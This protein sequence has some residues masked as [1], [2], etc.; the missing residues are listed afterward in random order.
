LDG[1][2]LT[3]TGPEDI[4]D[5]NLKLILGMVRIA[6][7]WSAGQA[8]TSTDLDAHSALSNLWHHVSAPWKAALTNSEEG[9]SARDG[10]L[11]WCQRKTTPYDE[12]KVQNFKQS[13]SDG[14]A[15]C[16]LIHRHRPELIDWEKLDKNDRRG[17]TA[18]AFKVAEESLGIPVRSTLKLFC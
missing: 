8:L 1:S 11:L 17:N 10:L 15:F 6:H 5:G 2:I 3:S 18:L 13:W 14:L 4:V 12:V 16:A 9:L 7:G